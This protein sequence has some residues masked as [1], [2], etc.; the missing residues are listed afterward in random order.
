MPLEHLL[1]TSL[2]FSFSQ[3]IGDTMYTTKYISGVCIASLLCATQLVFAE[4]N[5]MEHVI[6]SGTRSAQPTVEI[7]ASIQVLTAEQI[8]L[9][10]ANNL[11]QVLNAQAGLTVNDSIGNLG[12]GATISMRGF[13]GNASNNVLVMVDGRKLNNPSL[14]GPDLASI[15]IKDIERVEIIQGSAGSL[16]GE[17]SSGGVINV[18]TRQTDEFSAF[19][20]AG[21]GTD[22]YEDYQGAVSQA[23]DNG[24]SY[25]VSGEKKEADNYR[26]NNKSDYQ[27]LFVNGGYKADWFS[28]FLEAQTIDDDLRLPGSLTEEEIRQDRKQTLNPDD[29]SDRNTDVYRAGGS[30]EFIENWELLGEY[31]RREEDTK[32][33]LFGGGFKGETNLDS[34]DPRVAGKINT[35]NGPILVTTGV[36]YE[37]TD[38]KRS[39]DFGATEV[40]QEIVDIYAQVIVPVLESVKV[41]VGARH[42][43][44]EADDKEANTRFDDDLDVYQAG[45]AWAFYDNSRVFLRR[46]ES[47]RWPNADENGFIP[48]SI[49]FLKPQESTSWELGIESTINKFTLS[50]V[51]YDMEVDNEIIYDPGAEGPFGPGS[52]ANINLDQSERTGVVLDGS[53]RATDSIN[54]QL[55]YSYVDADI[56]SG[57]FDGNTVPFVAESTA[58][59][60]VS[61][62]LN[63]FWTFY[64]DAQYTGERYPT[65]DEANEGDKIGDFTIFNANIRFDY[66]SAYANL[67]M[68]NITGKEYNGF[69]GG[70]PPFDYNYP[71]PEETF[72]F[73]VGYNF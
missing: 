71:A 36:D 57:S 22:S 55:N 58:N 66:K 60:V 23:F 6:V 62:G 72:Q 21:A 2:N 30:L 3:K 20:E 47:F 33:F 5:S 73:S 28:A 8:K 54:V 12:R 56:S 67:R 63:E 59:L 48:P 34:F 27:N 46:D 32:G 51:V 4:D 50:A 17:Q 15:A 42:S 64:A 29:H 38:Y 44:F 65:G 13:G 14:A 41:T 31:N 1:P 39:D 25:R 18:I 52:G 37:D 26:D 24:L 70:L 69:S 68:N 11:V 10:G 49:S 43:D 35:A 40:D 53:W 19:V 7:P 9:S 16:Y 45:V 61:Y